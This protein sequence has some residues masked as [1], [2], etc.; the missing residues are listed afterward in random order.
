MKG[1][2]V[3]VNSVE[4]L[5]YIGSST[6]SGLVAVVVRVRR[7]NFGKQRILASVTEF[8]LAITR[9]H[10]SRAALWPRGP[11]IRTDP[12]SRDR[13][14]PGRKQPTAWPHA[15]S[16]FGEVKY[17]PASNFDYVNPDA[18]KGGAV[19]QI[20]IGTF[21]NFNLVVAAFKGSLA[22]PFS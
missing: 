5:P 2:K 1:K 8:S 18:P 15:L 4:P 21:D 13:G 14:R 19:R 6:S 20:Q 10:L 9:R 7:A 12:W 22:A 11:C 16:L 17:P 3:N